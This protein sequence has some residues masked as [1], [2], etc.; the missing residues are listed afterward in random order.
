VFHVFADEDD[1]WWWRYV[2]PDATV[3]AG[4]ARGFA[5]RDEAETAIDNRIRA[6]ARAGPIHEIA[7]YA[8]RLDSASGDDWRWTLVDTEG[9]E[10]AA[11]ARSR[12][13]EDAV[14]TVRAIQ[15]HA[16]ETVVFELQEPT[17]LVANRDGVWEWDFVDADRA[18]VARGAA[19]AST[20]EEATETVDRVRRVFPTAGTLDYDETAFEVYDDGDR[21]Q[22]RLIDD[23]ESVIAAG[24]ERYGSRADAE[25][26]IDA[27][28]G[29]VGDASIL[30]I[31][32]AAFELHE[33]D[34]GEW[35]WRLL[36]EDGNELAESS[37]SYPS[38]QSAREAM[39]DVK[40]FGDDAL[41]QF[42]E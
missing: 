18:V 41:I 19:E 7:E 17:I 42:A 20:R 5:T 11:S 37:R 23:E 1:E 3:A 12:P 13:R 8:V 6:A 32:N 40:E 4:S 30:E 29:E 22:W 28:K 2:L 25:A 33:G 24:S 10:L 38:H 36:G 27:I 16:A 31:D 39:N 15:E 35:R 21:W 34:D 9:H 14:A 26:A